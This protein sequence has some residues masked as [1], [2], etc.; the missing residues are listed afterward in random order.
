[1]RRT[2]VLALLTAFAS[3]GCVRARPTAAPVRTPAAVAAPAYAALGGGHLL[4]AVTDEGRYLTLEDGSVW[5]VEPGVRFQTAEWQLDA[6]ITVRTGR[7][8]N[9]YTYEVVNTQDD[10]GAMAKYVARR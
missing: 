3:A 8:E 9:G 2:V 10:E 1:M 4:R 5:E 7:G 6:P